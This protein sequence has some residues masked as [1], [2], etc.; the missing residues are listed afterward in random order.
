MAYY[1]FFAESSTNID[2]EREPPR[3][4]LSKRNKK[5]QVLPKN[6]KENIGW[7]LN[8]TLFVQTFDA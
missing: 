6:N 5:A 2:E 8:F 1:F 7:F 3:R 4:E